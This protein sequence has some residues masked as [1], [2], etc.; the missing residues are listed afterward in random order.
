MAERHPIYSAQA[1]GQQIGYIEDDEAFDLFD[2]ACAAYESNTGL[3]RDPKHKAVVGYVSLTDI[4]V[5]SSWMAQQLF[6][7]AES[8]TSQVS[9]EEPG[10]DDSNAAVCGA[11]DNNAEKAGVVFAPAPPPDHAA[12][13]EPSVAPT[14]VESENASVEKH[15]SDAIDITTFENSSQQDKGIDTVLTPTTSPLLRDSSTEQPAQPQNA[16]D[17]GKVFA[18]GEPESDHRSSAMGETAPA[19]QPEADASATLLASSDENTLESAQPDQPSGGDGMPPAVEAFMRHLTEYLH[20]SNHQ[21]ATL[22]SDDAAEVKL[23]PS[24]ETQRDLGRVLFRTE[25][26]HEGE[27]SGSAQHSGLTGVDREHTED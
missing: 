13:N 11:E 18:S 9:P 27:S 15:T 24:A 22:S 17:A 5:G 16:S 19:L 1:V 12:K 7:K 4:F 8:V 2:R 3:L 23:S 10:D 20:S 25:P 6:F 26:D 21:T 14:P